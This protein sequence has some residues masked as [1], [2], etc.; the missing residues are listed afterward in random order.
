MT[1]AR[2]ILRE[3]RH[4]KTNFAL[5]VLGAVIAVAVVLAT[6]GSLRAYDRQTEAVVD[7]MEEATKSEMAKLEDEIRKSMKGLGFNLFIFPAGQD[8]GEVY[9][10]GFASKT[11]P[12]AY[13]T[14]LAE[15]GVVTVNHLLPSLTKKLE[16]P[17]QKRTVILIGVRGEVPI[18]FRK[19]KAPIIDPV[20]PGELVLGYELHRSLGLEKGDPVTFMGKNFKVSDTYEARGSKDDITLWMNLGECQAMLGMQEKINAIQALECNCATVDRL[21]EIRTELMEILPDTQII[22]TQ[23]TALARAEARNQ[24]S[25]TAK[26]QIEAKK[27]Q[28]AL[29]RA[30]R[31]KLAGWLLPVVALVSMIWIGLLAFINVRERLPEIGIL[32]AIGVKGRT[33]LGAFLGRAILAGLVGGI[34][35]AVIAE[36]VRLPSMDSGLIIETGEWIAAISA[37]PVLAALAAWLPSLAA[38]QRDP[39]EVLRYD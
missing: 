9:S 22:E 26:A 28:R 18:A 31:E 13:V 4:R 39:A 17:E 19:P 38:A 1:L 11:M 21:G 23:S 25:A 37:A 35:G 27:E 12:E 2:L 6:L 8:M 34:I 15:S 10:E 29:L 7:Q 16:W 24:A 30:E 32:R 36:F 14:K 5:S 3:I 33:I 20:A